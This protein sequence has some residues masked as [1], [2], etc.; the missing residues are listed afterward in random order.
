MSHQTLSQYLDMVADRSRSDAFERAI[1]AT[2][3][4]K[5]VLDLGSG[6]GFLSHLALRHGAKKVYAMDADP[7]ALGLAT[8]LARRLADADRFVP[9]LGYSLDLSL[10]E[11]VDVIVSETLDSTGVG[12]NINVSL[13]DGARR[14]L[15]PGG[16]VIPH[17]LELFL[18]L[19]ESIQAREFSHA[20]EE[21][22]QR[23]GL[24]YQDF[25]ALLA[26][27]GLV[28]DCPQIVTGN[29]AAGVPEWLHWQTV[30]LVKDD[31]RPH[32]MVPMRAARAGRVRGVSTAWRAHLTDDIVLSSLPDAPGTHWKQAFINFSTHIDAGP[33]DQFLFE[34]SFNQT[35]VP[36]V[37]YEL[38]VRHARAA[39]R[40]L[41]IAS[42]PEGIRPFVREGRVAT[43][44]GGT[45]S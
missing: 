27:I 9:M 8:A 13:A 37:P 1:A 24:P 35:R 15:A 34:I 17:R 12:E 40:D 43:V 31:F 23:Y 30:D 21:A 29:D 38:A 41:F 16:R 22:G 20:W 10:P 7:E 33:G 14:F 25:D 39:H 18:G 3:P 26:G 11:Q 4:G 36:G 6:P 45:I 19:G 32:T 44:T 5:V 2:V 42:L 28:M